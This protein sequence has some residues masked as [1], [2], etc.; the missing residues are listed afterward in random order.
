MR[1]STFDWTVT[2]R[3][4][5]HSLPDRWKY[6]RI[7]NMD[8]NFKAEH[9]RMRRPENDI[10]ISDGTG[11]MVGTERYKTYLAATQEEK[12]VSLFGRHPSVIADPSPAVAKY[13]QQ[14]Q[15]RERGQRRS[16]QARSHRSR[17]LRLWPSRLCLPS[18]CV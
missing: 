10:A 4:R 3:S 5:D 13:V 16:A 7:F 12:R 11:F 1:T 15:S 17:R 8:G 6:T 9:M 14:P 2:L 18:S